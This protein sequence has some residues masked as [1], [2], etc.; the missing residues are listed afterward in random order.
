MSKHETNLIAFLAG[1]LKPDKERDFDVHLLNCE[2]CWAAVRD[3]RTARALLEQLRDPLPTGLADRISLAVEV[4]SPTPRRRVR[5][6]LTLLCG[7][8]L[9][10]VAAVIGV[11]AAVGPVAPSASPAVTA[12]VHFAQLIPGR[13]GAPPANP[14][15]TVLGTP[16]ALT[17]GGQHVNLAYYQVGTTEAVVASSPQQFAMPAGGRRVGGPPG[18]AWSATRAGITLFCL[19]GPRPILLAAAV[20]L[21][22]LQAL[23]AQLQLR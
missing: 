9:L 5:R 2:S 17:T 20:P 12:V 19:N 23:A 16:I 13:P 10:L 7:A 18:M 3:D 1:D 21:T 11:V 8:A 6:R 22:E 4:H 15:P 14:T